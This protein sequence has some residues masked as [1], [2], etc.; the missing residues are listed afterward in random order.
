[1]LQQID[2]PISPAELRER[3]YAGEIL[4]FTSLPE[5][6][7]FCNG[8]RQICESLLDSAE[9]VNS[10]KTA[11]YNEWLKQVYR[12]QL[13]ARANVDCKKMFSQALESI[14]LKLAESFCD[15]FIFRVVPPQSDQAQGTHSWVGTHRDTWGAGIYQQIN[16]WAPIYPYAEG[17]GI[18]FY[19]DYFKRPIANTTAEWRY[20]Q[21]SSA[22]RQQSVELKPRFMS[23]PNL[24]E[25]P[26]SAIFKPVIQ[27]GELLC[28]SAAHLHGSGT[29]LSDHC[30]F[31]FE[32]R[33]VNLQD[34]RSGCRAKNVD[35]DS[36]AQLLKL[37]SNLAD[38]SP[39]TRAHFDLA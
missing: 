11:D 26:T 9:P 21:F 16:W 2:Q 29:N 18:E 13:A 19:P 38:G 12:F 33:T 3:V 5:I 14:G 36:S 6:K 30:R 10:H 24:L 31:S 8:A 39:L 1:M 4:H 17:C 23:V 35:N 34:I 15:R 22:R 37:F 25:K 32:T 28:F 20:E 27:P 7:Q